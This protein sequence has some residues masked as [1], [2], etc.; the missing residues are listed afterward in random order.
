M[1]ILALDSALAGLRVSKQQIDTISA[2]VANATTPGYTRKILPQSTQVVDGRAVGVI[3]ETI[4]RNVDLNLRRD[5]WTQISATST[6]DVKVNYLQR[7]ENFHGAPDAELSIGAEMG[8]LIDSFVALS[9]SP[10]DGFLLANTV[11]QAFD[12]SNKIND[13]S[14]L[15]TTVRNDAQQEIDSSIERVND[16]LSQIA[17][18]NQQIERNANVGR[19]TAALEDF[20]DNAVKDLSEI[21]EVTYF[22]R[23]DGVL[24]VQTNRGVELAAETAETLFFT[25]TNIA[26]ASFY[27]SNIGG[28]FVGDP[29]DPT[30]PDITS[31]ALGG[32]LGGLI[33]LRDEIFPKQMAQLDELAH[34]LALRMDAQGLRLFTDENGNIPSDDA[35]DPTTLPDPTPVDYV[36]F[37]EQITVNPAV[38]ADN[39]LLQQGTVP[40]DVT[41]QPSS[42]EVIR[43]VIDFGFGDVQAQQLLGTLDMRS[44]ATGGTT[45]QNWLGVFSSNNITG[46]RTISPFLTVADLVTSANGA[47]DPPTE[48]FQISFSEPRDGIP[49]TTITVNLTAANLQPGATATEQIV[50]EINAQIVAAAV[51]AALAAT[52]SVGPNGEIVIDSRGTMVVDAS[53]GATGMGQEGLNFLGLNEGT[54][55]PD[56]PY[57]DIQIGE[58]TVQRITIE[59]GDTETEL[60]DKLILGAPPDTIGVPG[61]AYDDVTF[62][63][64]GE[65]ILRP[66]DDFTNPNFGGAISIVGGPFETDPASAVSPDIAALGAGNGVNIVSALFGSFNAGP[67]S[68]DLSPRQNISYGSVID[69]SSAPPQPTS[70]FRQ[71]LLGPGVDVDTTLEGITTLLDYAQRIVNSQSQELILNENRLADEDSLRELLDTQLSNQSQVNIDEE[72]GFLIVVQIAYSASARVV[73]AVDESFRELLAA[74]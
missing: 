11:D 8:R 7:I 1:G 15:I 38:V 3:G 30:S 2:N 72:L 41:I 24:V 35:P 27:P 50:A 26:P 44:F 60:I 21:M 42:N 6:L 9:D 70:P 54:F 43:R 33:E 36:G 28:I 74:V 39:S 59:P 12:M 73:T 32:T 71:T 22:E 14:R 45:L 56:D 64:T 31:T 62:A 47:L 65:L 19:T 10:N 48:E 37:S 46:G 57:F 51:P 61:L 25:S 18:L 17:E 53:F 55:A 68:E 69:A 34:K 16:L 58:D 29:S 4:I 20:R 23:G 5:L 40:T 49:P 63:A 13:F 66:G 67:P 52:A